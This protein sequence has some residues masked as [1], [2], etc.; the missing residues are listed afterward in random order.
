MT[1]MFW[2]SVL[3]WFNGNAASKII[4]ALR[5][6]SLS[7]FLILFC[8]L[9]IMIYSFPKYNIIFLKSDFQ[10]DFKRIKFVVL[11]PQ[12]LFII[13]LAR[14]GRSVA[15]HDLHRSPNIVSISIFIFTSFLY[16]QILISVIFYFWTFPLSHSLSFKRRSVL[17]F[18]FCVN[19]L[20]SILEGAALL[21][22]VYVL[23]M[24]AFSSS[25][26]W[27]ETDSTGICSTLALVGTAT[28]AFYILILSFISF[29]RSIFTTCSVIPFLPSAE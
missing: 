24:R 6:R 21:V 7:V 9:I 8:I 22:I 19:D 20:S 11:T 17:I 26:D 12:K 5:I 15:A 18:F 14:T 13:T 27:G 10:K 16:G 2:L 4:E 3:P 29:R 23:D 1:L 25:P 28:L